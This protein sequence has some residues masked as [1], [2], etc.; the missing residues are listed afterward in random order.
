MGAAI[1]G[2]G[3]GVLT[4]DAPW[5]DILNRCG[6][7]VLLDLAQTITGKVANVG[8]AFSHNNLGDCSGHYAGLACPPRLGSIAP[9]NIAGVVRHSARAGDTQGVS[10]TVVCQ[11]P[12]NILLVARS[13]AETAEFASRPLD[14]VSLSIFRLPCN[15]VSGKVFIVIP[16]GGITLA[17]H[18]GKTG[19]RC[20]YTSAVCD[21][22]RI[23]AAVGFFFHRSCGTAVAYIDVFEVVFPNGRLLTRSIPVVNCIITN[24]HVISNHITHIKHCNGCSVECTFANGYDTFRDI[25]LS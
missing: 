21:K 5:A 14:I 13:A 3:H 10:I 9:G 15:R 8:H 7:V 16:L 22:E 2:V 4:A 6:N 17:V 12:T 23:V 18:S 11:H 1:Q 20:I 25:N 19:F 24:C